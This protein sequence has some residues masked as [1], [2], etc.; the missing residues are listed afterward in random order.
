MSGFRTLDVKSAVTMTELC[1]AAGVA[2]KSGQG[3]YQLAK[4]EKVSANKKLIAIHLDGRCVQGDGV[5]DQVGL[6]SG[7]TLVNPGGLGGW[8]L[9]VQTTSPNRKLT[10]GTKVLIAGAGSDAV[11]SV[12]AVKRKAPSS[13]APAAKAPR[14]AP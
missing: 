9:F 6:G 11:P 13:P 8:S 5:R 12:G 10:P 3:F 2:Y 7:D 4:P 1:A 14:A